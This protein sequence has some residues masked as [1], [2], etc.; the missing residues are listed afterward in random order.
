MLIATVRSAAEGLALTLGV[1]PRRIALGGRSMGG[2]MCSMAV[3]EGLEGAALVLP[4]GY[5]QLLQYGFRT[6]AEDDPDVFGCFVVDHGEVFAE[7][8]ALDKTLSR[9]QGIL[10]GLA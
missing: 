2:R 9:L 4:F 10:H 6:R 3:A 5:E 7:T 1:T 8:A